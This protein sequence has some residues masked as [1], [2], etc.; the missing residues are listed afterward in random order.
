MFPKGIGNMGQLGGLVKQA[1]EM[2]G[3]IEELKEKLGDETIEASA[4]GGM[5][6]VVVN[7]RFELLSLEIDPE[8]INKDD[9]EML[10]TLVRAAVNEGVRKA[11]DMIKEKMNEMTGGFDL[12]GMT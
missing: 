5:V 6:N 3:K 12:P 4:G 9:P 11:Q 10:T 1:M 2:K 8:I 7:G